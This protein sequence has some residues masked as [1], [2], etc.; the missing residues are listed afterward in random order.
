MGG[1]R[2]EGGS[3]QLDNLITSS[4]PLC[5]GRARTM[6]GRAVYSQYLDM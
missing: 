2:G 5:V 1:G 3:T 6:R 4:G